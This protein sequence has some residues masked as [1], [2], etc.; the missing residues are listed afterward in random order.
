MVPLVIILTIAVNPPQLALANNDLE[1]HTQVLSMLKA[2]VVERGLDSVS[3]VIPR[4]D[5]SA[6]F[7]P[8]TNGTGNESV[9][10]RIV[11]ARGAMRFLGDIAVKVNFFG[12][13]S[14]G[15]CEAEHSNMILP[16]ELYKSEHELR[17]IVEH[18]EKT[19]I[20]FGDTESLADL[21]FDDVGID[22]E[23]LLLDTARAIVLESYVV[24][25][26]TIRSDVGRLVNNGREH[27]YLE[28]AGLMD[29]RSNF[30]GLALT[31][32]VEAF[33]PYTY[34]D[35]YPEH[36]DEHT[37]LG[38]VPCQH[39]RGMF[40][41]I[42]H[43]MQSRLNFTSNCL[44]RKDGLWGVRDGN[45]NWN[46]MVKNAIDG[47]VDLIAAALTHTEER[48]Q[49]LDFTSAM[50][51]ETY[52]IYVDK[53]YLKEHAWATYVNPLSQ[54]A[55]IGLI[56]NSFLVLFAYKLLERHFMKRNK[57]KGEDYRGHHPLKPYLDVVSDFWMMCLSYFGWK[58]RKVKPVM[59]D[60]SVRFL[61]F[62]TF[63]AGNM[64]F[65]AYRASLTSNLSV[66]RYKQPFHDLESFQ[67]SHYR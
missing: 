52:T 40:S 64:V 6:G 55:W 4:R 27:V 14:F 60:S 1:G 37:L 17:H 24:N 45:G 32:A 44:R 50:G 10:S 49:V 46:G 9:G 29:R 56:V 28:Y 22:K 51:G 39:V 61:L 66:K 2:I 42:L 48:S 62:C 53:R 36:Y 47:D 54:E 26:M 20:I 38:E 19:W 15:H 5:E 13:R 41:D 12:S 16:A 34:M 23:V 43:A 8:N 7:G 18:T 57:G 35:K 59:Q 25:G 63:F 58:P 11:L 33:A 3:F 30:Q 65:M 67:R 31:E 21:H